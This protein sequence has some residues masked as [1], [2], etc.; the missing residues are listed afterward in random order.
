MY[1]I[2]MDDWFMRLSLLLFLIQF[3]DFIQGYC[4]FYYFEWMES[5]EITILTPEKVDEIP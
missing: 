2:V 4:T 3:N 1:F 5:G